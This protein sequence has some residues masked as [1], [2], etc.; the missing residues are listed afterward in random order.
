MRETAIW[1]DF[2]RAFRQARRRFRAGDPA[3]L[4][5][6]RVALRRVAAAAGA[7]DRKKVAGLADRLARR[8]SAARQTE[9][10]RRLLGELRAAESVPSS[11][12]DRVDARLDARLRRQ[13]RKALHAV[14]GN[15][16]RRLV[17]KLKRKGDGGPALLER[18]GSVSAA[19]PLPR[20]I[21]TDDE[22]LH[23][24]RLAIKARRYLLAARRDLG[25]P[26][27]EPAIAECRSLQ[28]VLGRVNDWRSFADD[29]ARLKEKAGTE[30]AEEGRA[31]DVVLAAARRCRDEAR[32]AAVAALRPDPP[33]EDEAPSPRARTG[34]ARVASRSDARH[35]TGR[36][37][38]IGAPSGR[39]D[40]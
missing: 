34:N 3:G 1:K 4:H 12:A 17:S 13:R 32:V 15:S 18:M 40:S 37:L 11:V 9:V 14:E 39:G 20:A 23:R 22:S 27:L 21:G 36:S 29:L 19:G 24:A 25:V 2:R 7:A 31:F 6:V 33:P 5:D 8:L 38:L 10:D 35:S 26:G 16:A 28:D 30:D